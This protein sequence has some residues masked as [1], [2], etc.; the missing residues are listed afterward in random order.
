MIVQWWLLLILG[1]AVGTLGS[2]IGVG[3]G[4]ILVPV[5]IFLMPKADPVQITAISLAV[6]FLSATSGSIAFVRMK[7]V[8]FKTASWF[9]LA[10]LPGAILGA[11][12]TKWFPRQQFNIV[13]GT[14]LLIASLYL[15]FRPERTKDSNKEP[16]PNHTRR[17]ITDA[18][19]TTHVYHFSMPVGFGV[20]LLVGYVS[21]LL[22]IGGGI[23]HVP[24]LNRTLNF[25]VHIATAT[26]QVILG[27]MAL[28]GTVVH[29]VQG[30]LTGLYE[31]VAV[32]GIGAIIGSQV[33]AHL[34]NFI[35]GSGIIRALA[36]A[37]GVVGIRIVLM[38]SK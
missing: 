37:L 26:S 18:A 8:D 35:K 36:I 19:G 29:F 24:V 13:F 32:L 1:L 14:L 34:S 22:G 9:A 25:P 38:T 12:S 7:R 11:N 6:V 16:S 27:C 10:T 30:H 21:S 20:S 33:G 15:F 28:A 31:T 4:F 23:I 3:G 17:E 5:L 2:L